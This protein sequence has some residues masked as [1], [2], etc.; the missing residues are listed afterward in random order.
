MFMCLNGDIERQF[1]FVQ[2]TWLGSPTFHGLSC[3]QDALLGSGD[4][5]C[6]GFTV[7]SHDGPVRLSP[8]SRFVTVKG[9]GYFFLPSLSLLRYLAGASTPA[10]TENPFSSRSDA[11]RRPAPHVAE[12]TA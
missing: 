8:L 3:E 10:G 11:S 1:E 6:N 4:P 2:Q 9:G 5:A 12:A 7:P